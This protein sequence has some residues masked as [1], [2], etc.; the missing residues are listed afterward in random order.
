MDRQ[1]GA[2]L[3]SGQQVSGATTNLTSTKFDGIALSAVSG[4][5]KAVY[6][7]FGGTV[8]PNIFNLG[9]G[10]ACAIGVNSSGV[11]IRVT[12]A[13]CISAPNYIGYCDGYG[14]ITVAPKRADNF[15]IRDF[16]AVGDG[17]TDDTNAIMGM[18]AVA[19]TSTSTA[20]KFSGIKLYFPKGI[21][22]CS[23]QINFDTTADDITHDWPNTTISGD[24]GGVAN[25]GSNR[26]ASTLIYTGDGYSGDGYN[27]FIS[28]RSSAF[29]M[30][31]DIAV[32]YNNPLFAGILI[33]CGG[34]VTIDAETTSPLFLRVNMGCDGSAYSTALA[35]LSLDAALLAVIDNCHI[36]GAAVGVFCMLEG[37]ASLGGNVKTTIRTTLFGP[38]LTS[39]AV[40]NPGQNTTIEEC[41]FED[42]PHAVAGNITAPSTIIGL[43]FTGN[44][45][46]DSDPYYNYAWIDPGNAELC[47]AVFA[48]NLFGQSSQP[49]TNP[50][51]D[52]IKLGSCQGVDIHSNSLGTVDFSLV[53]GGSYPQGVSIHG[54]QLNGGNTTGAPF[55]RNL[56]AN[57][58][59]I[60]IYGN[61][62]VGFS[63][64]IDQ[65]GISGHIVTWPALRTQP[66][67]MAATNASATVDGND[68]QGSND[69]TGRITLTITGGGTSSGIQCTLTFANA[70]SSVGTIPK[71]ILQAE[72][73]T[74]ANVIDA[75]YTIP[76]RTNFIISSTI[77]LNDGTY[78]W[79]YMV[80]G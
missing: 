13:T 35:M 66:N 55:F 72:N 51:H 70:F 63:Q 2:H 28:A 14:T 40:Y 30:M 69:T 23:Q 57:S 4:S 37:S 29:F 54:N 56:T 25:S 31:N 76:S 9:D 22:L 36:A 77:G 49:S 20:G 5:G 8:N 74:T 6:V 33:D 80:M 39:G 71:I 21:Y 58:A 67:I 78:I 15:N 48:G 47:G 53:I 64:G 41:T 24:G 60:A 32:L 62:P 50:Q 19:K 46:G 43:R 44:W 26:G 45:C 17:Y 52:S 75:I 7:E 79:S 65:I 12:D 18:V 59:G 1:L 34:Y 38:G 10:Y 42:M 68:F 11:A 16:G 27:S 61:Y 3:N 73:S